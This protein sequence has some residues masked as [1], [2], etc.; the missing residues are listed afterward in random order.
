MKEKRFGLTK[1]E[2]DFFLEE[3]YVMIPD[4]F[5]PSSLNPLRRE[6]AGIIDKSANLLL[7]EG[8]L[9]EIYENEPFETRLTRLMADHPELQKQFLSDIEGKGGGQHTGKQ[10][11]NII[12]HP[13]LLSAMESLVGP[14]I[15]AS[16]VYRI[17]PKVPG[18]GRGVIPW[19]QDSGYFAP[20]CDSSL[21][22]TVWI[23]LVD[24]TV[25]NGC[26]QVLPRAHR[27]G[28]VKHKWGGPNGYLAVQNR[29]LPL[30]PKHAIT[31]PVPM[32]GALLLTNLTPHCST[33][34]T[35]DTIRWSIDLR[36]QS[37][38][39]PTNAFEMPED[40][41]DSY[42][43]VTIAC[44]APEGDFVVRSAKSQES[45]HTYRQFVTRRKRYESTELPGPKRGWSKWRKPRMP[46]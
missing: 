14:E 7:Q 33:P 22:V 23:P 18:L 30:P 34:N 44:Y 40:Y 28:V 41:D 16:S 31:V 38:S 11:F 6:I 43:E 21:I 27:A 29:D 37:R 15:V 32:G 46:E 42:P 35:T 25:E 19:H 36:Y 39:V 12:R 9:T 2:V 5:R 3:G 20:H 26:L 4:L 17:R 1:S 13:A 24:A 8:K 10:M 45:E